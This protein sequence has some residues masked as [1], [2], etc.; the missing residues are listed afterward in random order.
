MAFKQKSGSP[1]Q[2]NFGIGKSPIKRND[3]DLVENVNEEGL[4]ENVKDVGGVTRV[5]ETLYHKPEGLTIIPWSPEAEAAHKENERYLYS[6]PP[7]TMT[8]D[9]INA[10]LAKTRHLP[11]P[12]PVV[13]EEETVYPKNPKVKKVK[14][15]R[16]GRVK[17]VRRPPKRR[18]RNLVTGG[19]NPP[20][21]LGW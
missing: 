17:K 16:T 9:E 7:G 13:V 19:W 11:N 12:N 20:S 8:A 4:V 18:T 15:K 6:L 2:R 5:D 10:A 3:D 1:F 21:E 14:K